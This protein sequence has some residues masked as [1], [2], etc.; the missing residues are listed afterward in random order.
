MT[1]A[2]IVLHAYFPPGG[3]IAYPDADY[4][5]APPAKP[6]GKLRKKKEYRN[7]SSSFFA[8]HEAATSSRQSCPPSSDTSVESAAKR[9][10][11]DASD[12]LE[13][14]IIGWTYYP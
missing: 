14:V 1:W 12:I 2:R 10:R 7:D 6:K 11:H 13:A 5:A 9:P 3:V 4:Y 8:A